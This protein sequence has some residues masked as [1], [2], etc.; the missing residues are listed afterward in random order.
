[1]A[2]VFG[3]ALVPLAP[4]ELVDDLQGV[5][6]RGRREPTRPRHLHQRPCGAEANGRVVRAEL[7]A[8]DA[9]RPAKH[10]AHA[11][12]GAGPDLLPALVKRRLE[13][14][15]KDPAGFGRRVN[16]LLAKVM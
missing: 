15:I 12:L 11:V 6:G 10:R 1:M 3:Q 9:Q 7:V 16:E 8:E 13:R 5:G 4:G 14:R 2:G